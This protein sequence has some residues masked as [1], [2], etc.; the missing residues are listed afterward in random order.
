MV[1]N[2]LCSPGWPQMCGNPPASNFVS[3]G[4]KVVHHHTHYFFH[5]KFLKSVKLFTCRHVTVRAGRGSAQHVRST[6]VLGKKCVCVCVYRLGFEGGSWLGTGFREELSMGW[7]D[8]QWTEGP[9][10]RG[11]LCW[12]GSLS[13][14]FLSSP[15]GAETGETSPYPFPQPVT[16]RGQ[17]A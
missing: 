14:T 8:S 10:S 12:R 2:S 16:L 17:E 15:P 9:G 13:P 1:Q 6:I 3:S 5:T 11:P 4:I 7:R